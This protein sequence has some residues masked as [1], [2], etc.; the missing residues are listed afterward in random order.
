MTTTTDMAAR[1]YSASTD[2][3][4]LAAATSLIP[5]LRSRSAE[6]DALA[7]LPDATI[8][9]FEEARLFEMLVPKKYGG[10]QSSL[11][12]FMDVVVEVGRGDGSAAWT[13]SLTSANIWM[14][15]VMYPGHVADEVFS[16]GRGFRT[17]GVLTP[18]SVKT[19]NV[20]G[21]VVIEE[22]TWGF[23]SGVYHAQWDILTIPL[24]NDAGQMIDSGSALVPTSQI[25]LLDDW[26]TIGLRGSGSTSISVKDVFV[27]NERIARMSKNL[28]EDYA[29]KELRD[30]PL[31]RMPLIPFLT[32]KLVFPSLG[33]A[34]AALE[35]FLEKAPHRSVP[36]TFYE[37]LDE[38]PITHLQVAEASSKI[39]AAELLLGQSVDDLEESNASNIKMPLERRARVWRNAGA[40]SRLIWEAVDL[41]AGASG[42]SF[43]QVKNPMNRLWRDV[44]VASMHGGIVPSSTMEIFG[45]ILSG[46]APNTPLL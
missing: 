40:A 24:F 46:K 10:L 7:R 9:E 44:R 8:A 43:A 17:T 42:G 34:K 11:R 35:L 29:S 31:Y 2:A 4:L 23:N 30:E 33:M 32:T 38:A 39:D 15:A 13:L 19:R 1:P 16:N 18:R 14:A 27:P 45:R 21:G 26:D 5:A 25:T 37:K 12:T 22:G 41:L 36:Y 20:D 6:T 3:N 28:Q